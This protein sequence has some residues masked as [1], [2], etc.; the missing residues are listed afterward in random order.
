MLGLRGNLDKNGRC[1]ML[2]EC[3][4]VRMG[5]QSNVWVGSDNLSAIAAGDFKYRSKDV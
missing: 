3:E 5:R 1:S 2:D 4:V